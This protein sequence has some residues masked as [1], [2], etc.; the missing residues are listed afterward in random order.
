M[1]SDATGR[2]HRFASSTKGNAPDF[3]AH[4]VRI[5]GVWMS[6]VDIEVVDVRRVDVHGVVCVD[7]AIRYPDGTTDSARLGS[8]SVPDGL[9]AGEHMLAMRFANMIVSIQR[10]DRP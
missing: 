9:R 7:V 8:E 5:Q 2:L 3:T 1:E 4:A 10:Q 6:E